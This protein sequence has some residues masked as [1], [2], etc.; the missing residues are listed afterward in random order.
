VQRS[1]LWEAVEGRVLVYIHKDEMLDDVKQ[2]YPAHH[3]VMV[4][5]KLRILDSMKRSWRDQLTT[6]FPRQGHYANDA[7]LLAAFPPPDIAVDRISALIDYDLRDLL[8]HEE[9][10]S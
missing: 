3:Y 2:R 8:D 1:G 7:K 9:Q 6:V 10:K 4:D 5:D